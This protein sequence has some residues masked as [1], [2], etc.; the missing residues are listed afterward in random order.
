MSVC[1]DGLLHHLDVRG[2]CQ[3][4]DIF[5]LLIMWKRVGSGHFVWLLNAVDIYLECRLFWLHV[6]GE[7]GELLLLTA[8]HID[9]E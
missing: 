3:I 8:L 4:V 9:A 5:A 1:A 7:D 6:F 2:R